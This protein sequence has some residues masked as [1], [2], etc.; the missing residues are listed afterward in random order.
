MGMT[1]LLVASISILY[2]FQQNPAIGNRVYTDKTRLRGLK[3]T[4]GETAVETASTQTKP[5]CAG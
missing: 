4:L 2:L 3:I 5:A 1:P